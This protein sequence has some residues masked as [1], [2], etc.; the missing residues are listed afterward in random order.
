MAEQPPGNDSNSEESSVEIVEV[1]TRHVIPPDIV[2][3]YATNLVVQ[4]TEHE[5]ILSFFEMQR[6]PLIGSLEERRAILEKLEYVP[7]KCFARIIVS[8]DRFPSFVE[9][10]QGNLEK[11][12]ESFGLEDD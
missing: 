1:P 9:A 2:G 5:F 12:R 10:L 8:P 7:V 3:Q 6:P 11:Y 4:H